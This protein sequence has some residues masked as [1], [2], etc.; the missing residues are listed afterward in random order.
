M[1]ERVAYST[2]VCFF[3]FPLAPLQLNTQITIKKYQ[4]LISNHGESSENFT[5]DFLTYFSWFITSNFSLRLTHLIHK[6]VPDTA[7]CPEGPHFPGMLL[8]QCDQVD[9]TFINLKFQGKV[10]PV[11]KLTDSAEIK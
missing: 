10:P 7:P 3:S 8:N 6:H 5:V 11:T 9:K 4:C 2:K 1:G